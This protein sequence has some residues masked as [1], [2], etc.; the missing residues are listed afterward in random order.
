MF[1]DMKGV[2]TTGEP[3]TVDSIMII[4]IIFRMN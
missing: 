3:K 2:L 1:K 4:A